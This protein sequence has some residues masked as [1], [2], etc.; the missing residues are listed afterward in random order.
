V[1]VFLFDLENN[2]ILQSGNKFNKLDIS[3]GGH[4][5]KG[6]A[7]DEAAVREM[8]EELGLS[9]SLTHISTF[10]PSHA[11]FNHY[12]SI[13]KARTP[14]GWIFTETDEVSSIITMSIKELEEKIISEPDSFTHGFINAF[15]EFLS[16]E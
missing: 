16:H 8:S 2:L 1:G 7:Y 5:K 12:W 14:Q 15:T 3:V 13:Y 9:V 11:R 4:V 6:E 10:I